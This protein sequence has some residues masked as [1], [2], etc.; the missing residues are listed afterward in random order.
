M[1]LQELSNTSPYIPRIVKRLQR[2]H[3]ERVILF[4]SYAYG[5]PHTDSDIDL[6]VVLSKHGIGKTYR[7][8][9]QN[10]MLV[11][12]AL[13]EIER[14]VPIDTLVYTLDEWKL[15]LQHNSAFAKLIR[16]KGVV[17]YE[18]HHTRVDEQSER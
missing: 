10:R 5:I 15:F 16:R 4:G 9:R 3:P 7:E 6:I 18:A 12:K 1:M 8:K 14:E 2:I 13:I 11:G 17:L